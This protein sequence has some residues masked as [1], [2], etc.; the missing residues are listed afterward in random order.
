MIPKQSSPSG[1]RLRGVCLFTFYRHQHSSTIC[2]QHQQCNKLSTTSVVLFYTIFYKVVFRF[3]ELPS[4]TSRQKTVDEIFATPA[5]L[6]SR[7]RLQNQRGNLLLED[8]KRAGG[9]LVV[10]RPLLS[11]VSFT[12]FANARV[13][14]NGDVC[15]RSPV[16]LLLWKP[17]SVLWGAP[18][19]RRCIQEAVQHDT[20]ERK[21]ITTSG[22]RPGVGTSVGAWVGGVGG[23]SR[24][25]LR[26][27]HGW[28]QRVSSDINMG[29]T[30]NRKDTLSCS[31]DIPGT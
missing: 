22:F 16:E 30:V 8:R 17:T 20:G 28:K 31:Q 2:S 3:D 19:R 12:E 21:V 1:R 14:I 13:A 11:Y 23:P 26:K 6:T 29:L 7:G 18:C 25:L 4:Q 27:G 24:H 9:K 10:A 5:P 15:I